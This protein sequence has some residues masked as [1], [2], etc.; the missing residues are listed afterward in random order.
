MTKKT[1]KNKTLQITV[2]SGISAI[3]FI[4]ICVF[5]VSQIFNSQNTEIALI[6]KDVQFIKEKIINLENNKNIAFIESE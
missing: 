4:V 6:K 1:L 3:I 5:Q 2:G